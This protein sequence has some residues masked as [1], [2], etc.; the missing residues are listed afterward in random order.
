MRKRRWTLLLLLGLIV[1]LAIA[2]V[3]F[4]PWLRLWFPHPALVKAWFDYVVVD[5]NI[6]R[7]GPVATLLLVG[8]IELVWALNLGRKSSSF[9]RQS[10]RQE[11]LQAKEVE[12]LAREIVLLEDERNALQA[13]L[14]LREDLLNEERIRLW[15]EFDGL[16]RASGL[17][18]SRLITLHTLELDPDLRGEWRQIISRLERIESASGATG[19][20]EQSALRLQR[21]ADELLRL[22]NACYY[23]GQYERALVHYGRAIDALPSDADALINHATVNLTLNRYQQALQDL[24]NALKLGETAWAYLGRG[25]TRER[26][27]EDKRALEDYSRAVRLDANLGEAYYHRGLL[28]LKMA[29]FDKAFQDQ[30]RVLELDPGHA[31]AFAARGRARAALG[32]TQW[33]LSDLDRACALAPASY[34]VYY[35]RGLVRSQLE[36]YDQALEDFTQAVELGPDFGPAFMA[37]GDAYQAVGEHWQAAADYGRAIELQPNDAQAYYA[38]GRAR[39]ALKEYRRAIEDYGQALEL[40][41][42]LAVSLAERGAAYEKLGE[43]EQA[44]RD[45][46]RAIALDPDLAIAYYNRGLVYGSQGE[47]DRAS[48]DLNKAV[49][50]DPSLHSKEQGALGMQPA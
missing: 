33:A 32:D 20:R 3:V 2:A 23:L 31:G 41:P 28:F 22:G 16:Q 34:D 24:D 47:Y 12:V 30:N 21:R 25:L 40:D 49:E 35:Y 29:E 46:D 26:M 11:R 42:A 13:E 39:A 19:R 14:D 5:L 1:V 6:G 27:G 7:W 36:A 17:A 10:Q 9:E 18:N 37:R 48:R 44:I 38:R 8:V 50:L 45:L 43:Y 4:W 15:T